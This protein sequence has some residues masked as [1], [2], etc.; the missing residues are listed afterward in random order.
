MIPVDWFRGSPPVWQ[1]LN[2]VP[3]VERGHDTL[4]AA[5]Q[6]EFFNNGLKLTLS[7]G[8]GSCRIRY[9]K[10]IVAIVKSFIDA[11]MLF[12]FLLS[13]LFKF[14]CA[15]LRPASFARILSHLKPR[16]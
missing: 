9:D 10:M 2:S 12:P 15:V 6:K 13:F 8:T 4:V 7:T 1:R 11:E 14:R 3:G 5:F 16:V